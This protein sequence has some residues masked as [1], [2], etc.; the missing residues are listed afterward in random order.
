MTTPVHQL[1]DQATLSKRIARLLLTGSTPAE[2]AEI[3]GVS[4][5]TVNL[6]ARS[7]M[8]QAIL[9]VE[10]Q[11]LKERLAESVTEKLEALEEKAVDAYRRGL[12]E[13]DHAA[14]LRAA[15][16]VMDRGHHPKKTQ[17]DITH[18]FSIQIA[19]EEKQA[20]EIACEE[21]GVA[22]PPA[23]VPPAS[24]VSGLKHISTVLD[25]P[26]GE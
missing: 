13:D 22:L 9:R 10:K 1:T 19:A 24:G 20:I 23:S 7:P 16:A 4:L 5:Q 15:D 6:H 26:E 18:T 17:Q 8:F 12:E 11:A 3:L 14:Y 25:E 2:T 21:A